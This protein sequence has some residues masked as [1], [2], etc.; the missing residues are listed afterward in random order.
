MLFW[1]VFFSKFCLT[2]FVR[3]NFWTRLIPSASKAENLTKTGSF[4]CLGST[5][6]Q[7]SQ[8]EKKDTIFEIFLKI[9]PPRENPRSAPTYS[10]NL[11]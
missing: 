2:F 9:R 8:P 7:S 6:K 5:W 3:Q 10:L 4:Y 11:K 1:P